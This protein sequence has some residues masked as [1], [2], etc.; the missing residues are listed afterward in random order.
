MENVENRMEA[1]PNV[2]RKL[3]QNVNLFFG[4][5]QKFVKQDFGLFLYRIKVYQELC[6]LD[7]EKSVTYC[8]CFNN[9]INNDDI[10][11]CTFYSNIAWF[12]KLEC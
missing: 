5:S 2:L 4:T 9:I 1:N 10:C 11:D 7:Y 8:N 6:S 3:F 12:S